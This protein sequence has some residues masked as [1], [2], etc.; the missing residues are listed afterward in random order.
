MGGLWRSLSQPVRQL[1]LLVVKA[2]QS[3]G[4]MRF[5]DPGHLSASQGAGLF[6]KVCTSHCPL[7]HSGCPPMTIL[8]ISNWGGDRVWCLFR[9][10][11]QQQ[12]LKQ[13]DSHGTC[14]FLVQVRSAWVPCAAKAVGFVYVWRWWRW[15]LGPHMRQALTTD[16]TPAWDCVCE[17]LLPVPSW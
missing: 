10:V 14:S 7:C 9:T 3:S 1:S 5:W 6:T 2:K 16:P 12:V 8:A 11:K 4:R 17:H 15:N 13:S